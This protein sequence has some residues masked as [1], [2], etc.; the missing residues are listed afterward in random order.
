MT[1]SAAFRP[2][3]PAGL[4]AGAPEDSD[5]GEPLAAYR[6]RGGYDLWQGLPAADAGSLLAKLQAAA[7]AGRGGAQFP[8]HRKLRAVR[9]RPGS[10]K[11]VVVNGSEHEPGSV[12]DRMLLARL[13]HQVLE[14]A[15]LAAGLVGA[16]RILVA[17]NAEAQAALA[18]IRAAADA[19]RAAWP[20]AASACAVEVVPVPDAY[21]VGE[22]T[23]LLEVLEGREPLPRQRPPY[24][25]EAGLGGRPTLVH[26]VETLAWLP[27]VLGAAAGGMAASMLCSLGPEFAHPGVHEVPL[28]MPL[29]D[30]LYGIGGG[31]R[32]GAVLQ[33]VQVGGPALA[34]LGP[35]RF[36]LPLDEAALRAA[37]SGLG[38]GVVRGFSERDCMI[39]VLAALMAFFAEASCGQCP[40]CR[41]ETNMCLAIL[42]QVQAGKGSEALL[43]RIPQLFELAE[44][45]G[46][47]GLIAMPQAPLRSGLQLFEGAF[48]AHLSGAPCPVCRESV[49]RLA[50]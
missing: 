24:P 28:G 6:E 33:A 31:L 30:L 9:D 27:P 11:V 5:G 37:G 18:A 19:W 26:N 16:G 32:D 46:L 42:R 44:G 35:D 39:D 21:L 14:G 13:P 25:T 7:L 50:G 29:R 45:K 38:C 36:D 43:A 23:A 8:A 40:E 48:A 49:T 1:A 2:A 15:L 4:L 41:M 22:E 12:K 17:V 10:D 3:F 20:A 34:F 47:C